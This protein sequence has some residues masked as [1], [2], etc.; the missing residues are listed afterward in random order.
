MVSEKPPSVSSASG[1]PVARQVSGEVEQANEAALTWSDSRNCYTTDEKRSTSSSEPEGETIWV[2]FEDDEDPQAARERF[3]DHGN[4]FRWSRAR[5]WAI[6]VL[7]CLFTF[8]VAFAGSSFPIGLSSM[9]AEL[10][11][12]HE[13]AFAAVALYPFGF[14]AFHSKLY[15]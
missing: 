14:V 4:P 15:D 8:N 7:L 12:S 10:G 9:Q 1:R 6:T 13:V 3:G 2:E 11:V 5:K